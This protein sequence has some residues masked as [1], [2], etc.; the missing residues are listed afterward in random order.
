[1]YKGFF[2]LLFFLIFLTSR[3]NHIKLIH[4]K[5]KFSFIFVEIII[6]TKRVHIDTI[7]PYRDRERPKMKNYFITYDI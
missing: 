7:S 5:I 6:A 2:F 4:S 1:M 3:K